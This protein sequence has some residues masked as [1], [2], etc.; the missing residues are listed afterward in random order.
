M[1]ERQ[2]HAARSWHAA[3]VILL[4]ACLA[5]AGACSKKSSPPGAARQGPRDSGGEF[6]PGVPDNAYQPPEATRRAAENRNLPRPDLSTPDSQYVLISGGAQL[7]FLYQAFSGL[8]PD[9]EKTA[10]EYSKEYAGTS[11]T[12]RRHDLLNALKPKFASLLED[13]RA[14]PYIRWDQDYTHVEHYDFARKGF[15]IKDPMLES[16]GYGYMADIRGYNLNFTNGEDVNFV[17]VV[18]EGRARELE[19]QLQKGNFPIRFYAFVQSADDRGDHVI[20]ASVTK[21]QVLD[22]SGQVLL[23]TR[24]AR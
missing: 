11:D 7:M 24:A 4:A 16:G 14:H 8:P 15:L 3:G 1:V 23:E 17:S 21:V 12:F 2:W 20:H 18:D 5:G 9:I 6:V 19:A 22:R 10:T 13:A